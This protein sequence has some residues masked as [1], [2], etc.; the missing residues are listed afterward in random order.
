MSQFLQHLEEN[1]WL[2]LDGRM[3]GSLSAIEKLPNFHTTALKTT[4]RETL[5]LYLAISEHSVS[6]I[7][8]RKDEGKQSPIYYVSKALLNAETW[9]SQL[10]KLALALITAALKLRPYFQC[11]PI[12][13]LTSFPLKN[14][15]HKHKLSGRLTKWAV[16][17]SE[18]H[19]NYQPR[20]TIKS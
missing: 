6:S 14:I 19:I 16:K 20:A 11:H 4:R 3:W 7:L 8:V 10:E 9:Y 5:F 17:L 18:H 12:T 1:Y 2:H 15:L 13:V